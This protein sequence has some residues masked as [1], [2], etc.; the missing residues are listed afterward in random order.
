MD[1][2]RE[3]KTSVLAEKVSLARVT[4]GPLFT[5]QQIVGAYSDD[6]Y[7]EFIEEWVAEVLSTKYVK[8]RRSSGSGDMGRDVIAYID[9]SGQWDNYQ[10]KHYGQALSPAKVWV[11][12]GKI[13]YYTLKGEITL[14]VKYYFVAQKGLGPKLRKLIDDP[15]K[16]K[17]ELKKNWDKCCRNEISKSTVVPLA[18]PLEEL[19]DS[20]DFSMFGDVSPLEI[21]NQFKSSSKY[22]LRFGGGL[23]DRKQNITPPFESETV[24]LFIIRLLEAYSEHSGRP[25]ATLED[26]ARDKTYLEHLKQQREC[27]YSAESLRIFARD[28]LPA[29]SS[30]FSDF[31][32]EIFHGIIDELNLS[33]RDGYS[34]VQNATATASKLPIFTGALRD[35]ISIVDKKGVCH[36]LANDGRVKWSKND[37]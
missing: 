32:D 36:Q 23:P 22:P 31:Q 33:T 19:I 4:N 35:Y 2:L 15:I 5:P 11:E 20:V 1:E 24:Q 13:F 17:A 18:G 12:I 9:N 16:L 27:Y 10:C 25:L 29:E 8:V 6:Q 3:I 21:I 37:K 34:N 14:P 7:E 26:V 28:S 30:V